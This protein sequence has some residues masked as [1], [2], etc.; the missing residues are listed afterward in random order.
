MNKEYAYVDGKVVVS[1]ENG[2]LTQR[3]YKENIEKILVQE[4]VVEKIEKDI[5]ELE[6]EVKNF[7]KEKH[8]KFPVVTLSVLSLSSLV[9]WLALNIGLPFDLINIIFFIAIQLP[10]IIIGPSFDKVLIFDPLKKHNGNVSELEYL[11]KVQQGEKEILAEMQKEAALNK[12]KIEEVTSVKVDDKQII[13]D[14]KSEEY[15]YYDVGANL[16]KYYLL[17][18]KGKLAEKL[19]KYYNQKGV[20]LVTEYVEENGPR[21]VKKI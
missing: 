8:I 7:K 21:L 3:D 11:K 15:L 1:D 9:T 5:K 13:A 12:D 6:E 17:Y 10:L 18:K 4:N 20:E 19:S 14:L 2:K 16:K